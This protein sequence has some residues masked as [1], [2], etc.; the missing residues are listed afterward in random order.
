MD[1]TVEKKVLEETTDFSI[2]SLFL[3]ADVIVKIVILILLFASIWSWAIIF[4]KY[5]QLKSIL[6][7]TEDFEELF[8]ASETLSKL[9][10]VVG[11]QPTHPIEA[12]F[13]SSM[14]S[15]VNKDI[16]YIYLI[17]FLSKNCVL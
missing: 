1:E 10:K 13:F 7:D 4:S 2:F 8:Y 3:Q 16:L 14:V 15:C 9:S 11:S 5:T 6:I 12:V 17:F